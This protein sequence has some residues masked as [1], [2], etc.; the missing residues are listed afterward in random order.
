M[1][2]NGRGKKMKKIFLLIVLLSTIF[3]IA[4]SSIK[5]CS[6]DKDC[7][8]STCCHASE[9]VPKEDGPDCTGQLCTMECVP[10]TVDCGQGKVKCVSGECEVVLN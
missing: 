4:C 5:E 6:V 1:I 8:T 2:Q 10:G 9:A 7:V 3:L